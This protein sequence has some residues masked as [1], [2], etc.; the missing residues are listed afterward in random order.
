MAAFVDRVVVHVA[1]GNGGHGVSSVH[2]EKYRPLG[3]PDGG[4]GGDGGDVVL[5]VDPNVHT[6]LD[7]H[8]HPHRKAGN[9]KPGEGSNRHGARGEDMVLRVP[10]GT[11]VSTPDGRVI[12]DLVGAGTRVVLASGGKG[13]LG[14]AA[15][16]NTRRKAPGFALLGEPGEGF[17]AVIE[18]KSIA[19]VGLVGFPS[20]GKSSLIAAMSSARPKIAD[21]PFTTLVP[22]LGVIR[23][24]DTVYTMADVPGLIP[25]AS[26]GK[27]LGVQFLRHVERCAVLVHVVDMATMEPGRDPESDIEALEHELR[28]YD[29]ELDLVGRL[30]I[31]VLNKID[32]PDAREL[33]DLVRATL[34]KRGLEVFPISAAT[35][36]GLRELGFALA[37]AVEEHRASLPPMEPARVTVTPKAVDDTGFTVEPDGDGGFVV[38]GVRVERWVR[39]TDFTNDE[40]V[41]FLADR[42]NRL[43]VEEQLAK[44]GAHEGDAVTIGE[45]TFDWVPT[46][47][48]GTLTIEESAG[49]GGRGTDSRID[50]PHRVRAQERLAAKKLRRTPYELSEPGWTEDDLPEDAQ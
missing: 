27:G 1:A 24:G 21:Y 10:A 36:E 17:D 20:A 32:V 48:A 19:D 11:V 40:A 16:A 44:A 42:L 37:R 29:E 30:R 28:E 34:E 9:G 26:T 49:L 38:R 46:L 12:A 15:L 25:G 5:E 23:S 3:G 45:V 14:N 39:Q 6:L 43:G 13:G 8:H 35:G 41:G 33:V 4:N 18:L 47:P 2:R 22:N 31:A 50:A 7:F